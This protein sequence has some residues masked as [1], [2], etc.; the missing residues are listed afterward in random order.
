MV[1]RLS[2][3]ENDLAFYKKEL[4]VKDEELFVVTEELQNTEE[5]FNG[6]ARKLREYE[7]LEQKEVL[8]AEKHQQAQTRKWF[9]LFREAVKSQKV[10]YKTIVC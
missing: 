10:R 6:T 5:K 8:L 2:K 9:S 3:A 1:Q 4:E 7:E